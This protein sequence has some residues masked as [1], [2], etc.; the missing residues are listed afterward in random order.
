M[1]MR[2][3]RTTLPVARPACQ[4]AGL[5]PRL[6]W[7]TVGV[8]GLVLASGLVTLAL[9]QASPTAPKPIPGGFPNPFVPGETIHLFLPAFGI[10]P[11]LITDF[12]GFVGLANVKGTGTGT[13]TTTGI[14]TPGLPFDSDVRFM[15]GVYVGRD[16]KTHQGTFIFV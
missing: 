13:D 15:T 9:G 14:S 3:L 1:S 6:F 11:S 5:A 2:H 8:I 16:G 4:R 7:T 12:N 10:E